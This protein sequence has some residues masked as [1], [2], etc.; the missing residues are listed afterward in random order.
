M[1]TETDEFIC[2]RFSSY[3]F[4]AEIQSTT[5]FEKERRVSHPSFSSIHY[6]ALSLSLSLLGI[7][8][9]TKNSVNFVSYGEFESINKSVAGNFMLNHSRP[10]VEIRTN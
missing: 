7:I 8:R 2:V 4:K 3:N 10:P 6:I 1:S 5:E 9:E